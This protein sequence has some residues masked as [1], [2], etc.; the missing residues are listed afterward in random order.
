MLKNSF[1]FFACLSM[2]LLFA[3]SASKPL[4]PQAEMQKMSDEEFREYF[5]K[6]IENTLIP[7]ALE[8]G[9]RNVIK[10]Y[11]QYG[12][13]RVGSYP[14]GVN[15]KS[16]KFIKCKEEYK[17]L[18]TELVRRASGNIDENYYSKTMKEADKNYEWQ[19]ERMWQQVQNSLGQET[20][21]NI[22]SLLSVD[23]ID[24]YETRKAQAQSE[25]FSLLDYTFERKF[26]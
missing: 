4:L 18:K 24:I 26:F 25:S 6:R 12:E 14:R 11:I 19:L 9:G 5:L 1:R 20:R 3:C 22:S 10:K 2:I 16:P 23:F 21:V 8:S 7:I 15:R 17:V 13:M